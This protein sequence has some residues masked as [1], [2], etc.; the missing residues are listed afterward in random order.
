MIWCYCF[1]VPAHLHGTL[2]TR[3]WLD[4]LVTVSLVFDCLFRL[5]CAKTPFFAILILF[6][7]HWTGWIL[8]F[9][10]IE[11]CSIT[12]TIVGL[13]CLTFLDKN[14]QIW[15]IRIVH[16]PRIVLSFWPRLTTCL[17]LLSDYLLICRECNIRPMRI[18]FLRPWCRDW[19]LDW[20]LNNEVM[21]IN[22]GKGKDEN[23]TNQ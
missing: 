19:P 21:A 10:N 5:I 18:N 23:A 6:D 11:L 22:I 16:P 3:L 4:I 7:L 2:A 20:A 13:F 15:K 14:V 8:P 1:L 17:Y 9:M 12:N